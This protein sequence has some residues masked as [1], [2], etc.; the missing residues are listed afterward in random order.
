MPQDTHQQSESHIL[1]RHT[2][3]LRRIL[4]EGRNRPPPSSGSPT[5]VWH[6]GVWRKRN[7]AKGRGGSGQSELYID[8]YERYNIEFFEEISSFLCRLQERGL[9]TTDRVRPIGLDRIA[10]EGILNDIHDVELVPRRFH[11]FTPQSASFT[12]WWRDKAKDGL[13][14]T[15][16]KPEDDDVGH[17][18][19]VFV[20]FQSFQDHITI[21]FYIDGAKRFTGKQIH[22][23]EEGDLG[24]RRA[25]FSRHLDN[26]RRSCHEQVV[27]GAIDLPSSSGPQNPQVSEADLKASA[28]YLFEG[29]WNEFQSAFGF[30]AHSP[31]IEG[32]ASFLDHGVIFANQRGLM[33]SIRGLDTEED[34][35]RASQIDDL[36]KRNNITPKHE[37]SVGEPWRPLERGAS[38]TLGPVDVFDQRCGEPEVVLKSLWPFLCQMTK[39]AERKDWVGCGILD[40]RALFVSTLGSSSPDFD[41]DTILAPHL[42]T[43]PPERFL[44]VTKGEPHRKQIGRFLE[45]LV[46]LETMRAIALKNLGTVQNAYLHLRTVTM[47]L[48]DI[49]EQW[50]KDRQSIH[51]RYNN[52]R[53]SPDPPSAKPTRWW[54]WRSSKTGDVFPPTPAAVISAEERFYNNL[55][56]LNATY[57][58]RLIDITASLEKMGPGGSGHLAHS[59]DDASY[60]I[61]EFDRMVPSLEIGNIAGWINYAQFADRGMRPTFNMIKNA[62]IRLTTAQGRLKS[63]TDIVQ[64]SALIVQADATR[65]NTETL[66]HIAHNLQ[67]LQGPFLTIRNLL[68]AY[69]FFLFL[70]IV[71]FDAFWRIF[72]HAFQW[73]KSFLPFT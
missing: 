69:F 2:H 18:L 9:C 19:R 8:E 24:E 46:A 62:G 59:I 53:P 14:N 65:R 27:S 3:H 68:G 29:I 1:W 40:W 34:E 71:Y 12:L 10:I 22:K 51:T 72:D 52:N 36:K 23:P 45:R 58:T 15:R 13:L 11:V 32:T 25:L 56:D 54:L 5:L 63:L 41:I 20:Q 44:I 28:D 37:W 57:E 7:H 67:L 70:A 64:V 31:N 48:D 66:R 4:T 6:I 21:T 30:M 39:D 49:L 16:M 50:A 26:I 55:G 33:M 38:S 47:E 35:R 61:G 60:Y 17:T 73:I 42:R 43:L